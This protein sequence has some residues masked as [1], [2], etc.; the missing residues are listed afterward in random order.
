MKLIKKW[1]GKEVNKKETDSCGILIKNPINVEDVYKYDDDSVIVKYKNGVRE[2]FNNFN[3][4]Q[5]THGKNKFKL[6]DV[7][8]TFSFDPMLIEEVDKKDKNKLTI[9]CILLTDDGEMIKIFNENTLNEVVKNYFVN[10]DV[11]GDGSCIFYAPLKE[12]TDELI[13]GYKFVNYSNMDITYDPIK[14]ALIDA[15]SAGNGVYYKNAA[16]LMKSYPFTIT[17][18]YYGVDGV[19]SDKRNVNTNNGQGDGIIMPYNGGI[20]PSNGGILGNGLQNGQQYFLAIVIDKYRHPHTYAQTMN[21]NIIFDV[22]DN[23]FHKP[24]LSPNLILGSYQDTNG[25]PNSCCLAKFYI[26]NL[27]IFNRALSTDELKILA[28]TD[29][30]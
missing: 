9:G 5:D 25:I 20:Y 3:L 27:R 8:K 1:T 30:N 4:L 24:T 23:R 7:L 2:K 22:Y 18:V 26:K 12:N 21:G 29:K 13:G 10:G 11:F 15:I 16:N 6:K 19:G 28:D 14:G 17:A